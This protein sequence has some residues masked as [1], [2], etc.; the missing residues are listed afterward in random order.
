MNYGSPLLDLLWAAVHAGFQAS[1][2][3]EGQYHAYRSSDDGLREVHPSFLYRP[4]KNL[5]RYYTW[6]K[7]EQAPQYLAYL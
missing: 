7:Q 1:S 3:G 4:A 2:D 5:T 6:Y